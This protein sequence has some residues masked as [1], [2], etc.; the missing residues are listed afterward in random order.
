MSGGHVKYLE[1]KVSGWQKI[2][3]VLYAA[4]QSAQD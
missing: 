3:Y 1:E 4:M 2:Y